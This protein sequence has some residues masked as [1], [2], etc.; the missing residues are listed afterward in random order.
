MED[1]GNLLL[2]CRVVLF[3]VHLKER[4]RER[5]ERER[6]REREG[7]TKRKT[8]GQSWLFSPNAK[9]QMLSATRN[10]DTLIVKVAYQR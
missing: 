5:G 6:R 2:L 9:P 8:K 1:K 7:M 4:E 10:R 3:N